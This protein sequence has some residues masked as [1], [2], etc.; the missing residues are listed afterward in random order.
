MAKIEKLDL[1]KQFK[2]DY[3][4]TQE[5]ELVTIEASPF[6]AIVGKGEPGGKEYTEKLNA[7]YSVAYT[8]KMALKKSGKDFVVLGLEGLWWADD[9]KRNLLEVPRQDWN[10]KSMI[11]QPDFV[12]RE[13]VEGPKKQVQTKKKIAAAADVQLE[14]FEEGKCVQILHI[15][16]Y[17]TE[18]S[19]IEKMLAF[20][21]ASGLE[22][23]G[24]HH[25]IYMSDPRRT[26]ESKLK[27]IIRLPVR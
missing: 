6:L 24:L 17:A 9:P 18:G 2:R 22:V 27:T 23:H 1:R 10:W 25:E 21:K 3:T 11:R 4:A 13:L 15:G 16:P 26:P 7:L 12:T 5:S 19:S 8:V 20:I 14:I